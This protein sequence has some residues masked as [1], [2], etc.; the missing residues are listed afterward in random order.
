MHSIDLWLIFLYFLFIVCITL[1]VMKRTKT[2]EDLFLAGRSL[3]WGVIGFSL[4]ASNISSTTLIGLSGA[5]FSS[6]IAISNYEWMAGLV[7]VF[8]AFFVIPVFLAK[9]ITTVPEYLQIRYNPFCRKYFSI[10]TILMS[11]MVDAA[12]GIYAGALV[13]QIFFPGLPMVPTCVAIAVFA[14]LYTA[15]GGLKAVVYTDVLQAIILLIGASVITYYVFAEF[16]FSWA[17]AKAAIPADHLSLVRPL[18]DPHLPWLGTLI[19]VPILGFW[20]WATNQYITQR[21]LG[22]RSVRH[23]QWGAMFAGL[24][25]L[26]PL[27]IMV[28]PGAMA[29]GLYDTME[30]PDQIFPRL[31]NDYLPVGMKG[32]VVA[33]LFA[34]IMST[35]DSTLNSASTLIIKDFADTEKHPLSPVQVRNWGRW[36]TIVLIGV[37]AVWAPNIA[38]FKGLFA[39]LQQAFAVVVPPV[40]AVFLCGMFWRGATSRA[41]V[42]TLLTGHT[43]GLLFFILGQMGLWTLHFTITVGIVTAICFGILIVASLAAPGQSTEAESALWKPEFS[44]VEKGTP[45]YQNYRIQGAAV[46]LLTAIMLVAFW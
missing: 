37:A 8:M 43:I 6:G 2:G 17:T 34:A 44:R 21:I 15:A 22:A 29:I 13:L 18:D 12:G 27:F 10:L 19:G 39:Y 30:N 14:G 23:A 24:L 36:T 42:I 46:V 4:F 25:K 3:G 16:N 31:V 40:V 32:I 11:I 20:Y 33:G 35:I 5:A 7:L 38:N 28:M 26:T 9:Q 41:A 45:F 1:V